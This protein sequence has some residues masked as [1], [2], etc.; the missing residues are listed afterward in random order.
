MTHSSHPATPADSESDPLPTEH[1]EHHAEQLDDSALLIE[2]I[3]Q[4]ADKLA[5]DGA[6][7]GDLKILS[8]A[9]RELRYAFK[10]FTPY[11]KQ[12]KITVFG[13]A[14]T[15]PDHPVYQHAVGFGR[16]MAEHGWIGAHRSRW[17]H[18]G[19]RE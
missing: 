18:Y 10:V 9:L 12:R 14:R 5:R 19:G 6:T 7:R 11:R 16:R 4:T 1:E 3:K 17:R 2:E 8:R 13:S 15:P